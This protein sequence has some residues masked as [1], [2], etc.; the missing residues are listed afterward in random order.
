MGNLFFV[1]RNLVRSTRQSQL[2]W[3]D[4]SDTTHAFIGKRDQD[5]EFSHLPRDIQVLECSALKGEVKT[6]TD[7]MHQYC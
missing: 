5:F 1:H 7:W 4:R 2:D 3:V 6:A